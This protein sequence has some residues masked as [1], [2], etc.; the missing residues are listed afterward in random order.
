[1]KQASLYSST[2]QGGGKRRAGILGTVLRTISSITTLPATT[3]GTGAMTTIV[4]I[5]ALALVIYLC[6]HGATLATETITLS[7]D[8]K[9]KNMQVS[10]DKGDP[11]S[12]VGVVV[13]FPDRTVSFNGYVVPITKIDEANVAFD[14][15]SNNGTVY[16]ISFS[17]HVSGSVDRV[18]GAV[19]AET[20]TKSTMLNWELYCKPATRLF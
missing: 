3:A 10:D 12:K 5:A 11:V 1:M 2:V 14:G 4:K 13:N 20:E 9:I 16:G 8:G 18:T 19:I 6:S 15:S 17:T 7:C